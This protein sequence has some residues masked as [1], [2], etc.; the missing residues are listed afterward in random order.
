MRFP[1]ASMNVLIAV[2]TKQQSKKKALHA[3]RRSF[4]AMVYILSQSDQNELGWCSGVPG[5]F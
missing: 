4:G 3:Q 1:Q 5:E 2:T